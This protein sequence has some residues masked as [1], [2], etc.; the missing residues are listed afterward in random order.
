MP[1]IK[2]EAVVSEADDSPV[3]SI[4]GPRHNVNLAAR[5]ASP[6]LVQLSHDFR[7]ANDDS[8]P[9]GRLLTVIVGKEKQHFVF[10]E[11]VVQHEAQYFRTALSGTW[12]ESV[13]RSFDLSEETVGVFTLFAHWL[14]FKKLD[15][16]TEIDTDDFLVQAYLLGDRRG[17]P[18]F[19][20]AIVDALH[21]RWD[22]SQKIAPKLITTIF[23][24]TTS[25]SRLRRLVADRWAWSA[26]PG[27]RKSII[28]KGEAIHH[29]F[30]IALGQAFLARLDDYDQDVSKLYRCSKCAHREYITF[31]KGD[32]SGLA[33]RHKV[34]WLTDFCASYHEHTAGQR[35]IV[36]PARPTKSNIK[37]NND[38]NQEIFCAGLFLGI[39][40][41]G[42]VDGFIIWVASL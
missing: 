33:G 40:L 14:Y 8:F 17:A 30:V 37:I 26:K 36:S 22:A 27:E 11:H 39:L 4:K 25:S 10:H 6:M 28:T 13:T 5:C 23:Q 16:T 3:V 18:N 35:C 1:T 15:F 21:E 31:S 41:C 32:V 20:N 42:V 24:E 19:Q 12:Q 38:R 2:D 34:P 9:S 29:E 7:P